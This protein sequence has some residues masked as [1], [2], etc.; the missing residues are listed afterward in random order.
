LTVITCTHEL[1][2]PAREHLRGHIEQVGFFLA[3]YNPAQ[4]AFALLEWRSM[5]AEAFEHQ[6]A[7]HVTLRDEI[8]P[9]IITW[10]FR[11]Q[12]CLIEVHSHGERGTPAFSPS[13]IGGFADWV[14][15]VR[16]RLSG[17]P[18][19]AIV[20][21][22]DRLDSIC[23]LGDGHAPEQIEHLKVGAQILQSTGLT[24]PRWSELTEISGV[25]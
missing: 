22:G 1:W 6:S 16:W 13:D 8:R 19:A 3:D 23:W 2:A 12:A 17:R 24:L 14:P 18:Y 9:E 20:T 21:V 4:Q 15:H 7:Y 25:Q 10:A 11:A 5:P